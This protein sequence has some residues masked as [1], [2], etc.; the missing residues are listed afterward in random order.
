MNKESP[1]DQNL[2]TIETFFYYSM[3]YYTRNSAVWQNYTRNSSVSRQQDGTSFE[4][5]VLKFLHWH[6]ASSDRHHSSASITS[7][8]GTQ[9]VWFDDDA[10][11][12]LS[13]GCRA[14]SQSHSVRTCCG[15]TVLDCVARTRCCSCL[16][17]QLSESW[18]WSLLKVNLKPR[19]CWLS[20]RHSFLQKN[21]IIYSLP[22][23]VEDIICTK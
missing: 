7:K 15:V 1:V 4:V 13:A 11:H 9:S 17:G 19:F 3:Y 5:W 20:H 2:V 18:S 22:K 6:C 16:C 8:W 12:T 21:C 23:F 14:V 10:T